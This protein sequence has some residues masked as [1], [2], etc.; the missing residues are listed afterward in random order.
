MG[1]YILDDISRRKED[2]TRTEVARGLV[3]DVDAAL[4]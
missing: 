2:S 3:N 1:S 4:G